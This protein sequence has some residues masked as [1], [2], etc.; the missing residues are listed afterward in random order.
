MEEKK[1]IGKRI[2][3]AMYDARLTPTDAAQALGVG[4]DAVAR[5]RRGECIPTHKR[6]NKLADMVQKSTNY[7][8]TGAEESP[9]K[10]PMDIEGYKYLVENLQNL[11]DREKENVARLTAEVKAM[12]SDL[13]TSE[14]KVKQLETE[15]QELKK[16]LTKILDNKRDTD[17]EDF[18]P[19][20][21]RAI[22]F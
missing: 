3:D 2:K 14:Q 13:K 8:L 5:W 15:N 11:H 16:K 10:K 1:E 20:E 7:L 21:L 6:L 19:E 22:N 9:E 18:D 4:Y 17:G 12:A